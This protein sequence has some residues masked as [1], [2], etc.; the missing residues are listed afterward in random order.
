[1]VSNKMRGKFNAFNKT[2][3]KFINQRLIPSEIPQE[4]RQNKE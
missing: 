2:Q 1:M 4:K 3:I